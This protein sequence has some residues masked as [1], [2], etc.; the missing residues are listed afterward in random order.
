MINESI[1][2]TG[3]KLVDVTTTVA[4]IA[5]GN[6]SNAHFRQHNTVA[7]YFCDECATSVTTKY[8]NICRENNYLKLT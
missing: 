5:V 1:I 8:Q 2:E 4:I 6:N 3:K 7:T